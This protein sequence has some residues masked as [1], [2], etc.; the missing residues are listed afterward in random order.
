MRP[1]AVFRIEPPTQA[2]LTLID[3]E[4]V[5]KV[6]ATQMN[7]TAGCLRH[8]NFLGPWERLPSGRRAAAAK[9]RWGRKMAVVKQMV[10]IS[11]A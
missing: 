10:E 9:D 2:R 6:F 8:V 7:G 3:A 4:G 5:L 1:A 11:V